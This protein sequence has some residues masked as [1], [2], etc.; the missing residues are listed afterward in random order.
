[1]KILYSICSL[2]LCTAS[3]LTADVCLSYNIRYDAGG[4]RGERDWK[5]RRGKVTDFILSQKPSVIGLQEVLYKQ[6]LDVEKKLTEYGR[7][8]VGRDD[9]KKRGEFSPIFY[10]KSDWKLDSNGTFWLSDT[11]KKPG[12]KSWGNGI[13]R[14]CTWARLL[15]P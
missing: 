8:G 11:P 6:L 10:R 12:S 9:A 15:D 14:I 2:W 3:F 5:Q 1:M 7:V 13:P 4:D